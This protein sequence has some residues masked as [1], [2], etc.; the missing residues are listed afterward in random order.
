MSRIRVHAADEVQWVRIGDMSRDP[1]RS[2][3]T[4]GEL[5]SSI[6][7]AEP[8]TESAPQLMEVNY[9]PDAVVA[10]HSHDSAE[11]VYVVEGELHWGEQVLGPG[12]SLF[13]GEGAVYGYRAG[14][15]GLRIV[16]FRPRA[17]FSFHPKLGG[18]GRAAG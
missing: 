8:G 4:Q 17:D 18:R 10:P 15:Q 16:N 5:E 3:L 12:A 14:P 11:I 9:V 2:G 1:S 6:R 13:I 7:Y